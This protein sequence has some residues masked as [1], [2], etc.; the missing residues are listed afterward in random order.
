MSTGWYTLVCK[1][2]AE[3]DVASSM[4]LLWSAMGR[5]S[6]P[7]PKTVKNAVMEHCPP[8]FRLSISRGRG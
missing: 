6:R 8:L 7:S 1:L 3:D 2:A 5:S 4:L